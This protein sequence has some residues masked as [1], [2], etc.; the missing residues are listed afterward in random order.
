[1]NI[2]P[3]RYGIMNAISSVT[4]YFQIETKNLKSHSRQ[5]KLQHVHGESDTG[6]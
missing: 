5:Q 2:A 4:P 1:M 6:L 3:F